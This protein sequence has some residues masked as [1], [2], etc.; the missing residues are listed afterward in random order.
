VVVV[1]V[2]EVMSV[3]CVYVID[4]SCAQDQ[5]TVLGVRDT[6]ASG[7]SYKVVPEFTTDAGCRHVLP[8]YCQKNLGKGAWLRGRFPTAPPD[9]A[10][11]NV[12][13]CRT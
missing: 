1:P 9:V 13:A 10:K 11:F 12:S 6:C 7:S 2:V 3:H 8:Q 5:S 4:G